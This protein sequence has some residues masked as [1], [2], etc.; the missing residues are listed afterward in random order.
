MAGIDNITGRILK[1]AQAEADGIIAKAKKK[2][3]KI[4]RKAQ[5]ETSGILPSSITQTMC[6][7]AHGRS[8]TACMTDCMSKRPLLRLE[9]T[10]SSSILKVSEMQKDMAISFPITLCT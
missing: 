1:D 6:S 4:L 5:A 7:W 3:D 8:R 2:A 10:G 9:V